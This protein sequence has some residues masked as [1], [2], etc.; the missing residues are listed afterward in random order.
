[1]ASRMLLMT[2]FNSS[3]G[4]IDILVGT[5]VGVFL[6]I[7]EGIVGLVVGFRTEGYKTVELTSDGGERLGGS[8][9]TML[10]T[11]QGQSEV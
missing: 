4:S 5:G 2:S 9:P 7:E 1:M 6:G 10:G 8:I 11:G 3:V